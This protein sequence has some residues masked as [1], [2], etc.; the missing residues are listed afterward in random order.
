MRD[1]TIREYTD[2]KITVV[3]Q[4]DLCIHS[5]ICWKGLNA[6]FNPRK[7]PWIMMNGATS[8]EIAAQVD[9][10]PSGALSWFRNDVGRIPAS[11]TAEIIVEVQPNGPLLV[12]GDIAIK[13]GNGNVEHRSGVTS[14]CRCGGSRN[15]PYCDSTH[16]T[17]G[18]KG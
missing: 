5:S 8:E 11:T 7:R 6:V 16:I 14:F 10:C 13:D 15:K 3:W 18:F 4:P 12:R 17:N 2:G 1:K 9:E